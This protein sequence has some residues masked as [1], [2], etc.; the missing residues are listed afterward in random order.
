MYLL[1]VCSVSVLVGR[2]YWG[3]SGYWVVVISIRRLSGMK[4]RSRYPQRRSVALALVLGRGGGYMHPNV[5]P[6][7]Q[8]RNPQQ[9]V[10]RGP[11][12]F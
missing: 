12:Q 5:K 8:P 2:V 6:N 9:Y 1:F 3:F 11:M 7:F 4:F 10:E